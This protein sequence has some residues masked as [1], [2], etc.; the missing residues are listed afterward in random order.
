MKECSIS[1]INCIKYESLTLFIEST[2]YFEQEIKYIRFTSKRVEYINV[3][4][5]TCDFFL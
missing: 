4:D 5:C 1:A 3:T 2:L